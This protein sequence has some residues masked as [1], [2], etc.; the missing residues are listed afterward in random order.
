MSR[1]SF[2]MAYYPQKPAN[3][4]EGTIDIFTRITNPNGLRTLNYSKIQTAVFNILAN[5]DNAACLS[6]NILY[7]HLL[8]K[9]LSIK[10]AITP[11][12]TPF[13]KP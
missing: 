12:I 8:P 7:N 11:P 10:R 1:P 4:K 3:C 5:S 6:Q 9:N 2:S 13:T